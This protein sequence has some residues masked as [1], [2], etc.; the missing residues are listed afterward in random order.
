MDEATNQ[1]VDWA[2]VQLDYEERN[3]S[4]E[5]IC[6]R[7]GISEAQ[8]RYKRERQFWRL[9]NNWSVRVSTLINRMMRLLDRQVRQ[10]E[11]QMDQ[12][13]DKQAVLLAG[14][15]K[16]LEKLI[17]LD[18]AQREKKPEQRREMSALRD[19]LAERIAQ[20]SGD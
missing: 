9:R 16:T 15:T 14:M 2:A 7:H 18:V 10:L 4:L 11:G 19:Q 1:S 8:L 5:A 6:K 12:P 13:S 20:L 3:G 17:E